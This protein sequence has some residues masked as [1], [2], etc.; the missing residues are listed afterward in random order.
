MRG[1]SFLGIGEILRDG[2]SDGA[3]CTWTQVISIHE[4][5]PCWK[6]DQ[7]KKVNPR[8]EIE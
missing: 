1:E 6:G 5:N 8:Q 7:I 3:A 4:L 2:L